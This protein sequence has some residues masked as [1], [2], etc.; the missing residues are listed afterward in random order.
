MRGRLKGALGLAALAAAIGAAPALH[1]ASK[2]EV[3]WVVVNVEVEATKISKSDLRNLYLGR[4][5]F[6]EGDIRA[7]VYMRS[8]SSKAGRAFLKD[9][10]AMAP[11]RY[12]HH[13]MSR[14]LSGQGVAPDEAVS[15]EALIERV[16]ATRGGLSYVL[17]SERT[18]VTHPRLRVIPIRE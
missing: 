11:S 12:R 16:A 6:L 15:L 18:K 9:V 1:G 7:K 10:L 5:S 13:W 14:Q 8:S 3:L 4:V 2:R 17:D